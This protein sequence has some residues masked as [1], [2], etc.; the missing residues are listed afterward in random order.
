MKVELV[1]KHEGTHS[2][3]TNGKHLYFAAEIQAWL[4]IAR[5]FSAVTAQSGIQKPD[6]KAVKRH[7]TYT[8][9]HYQKTQNWAYSRLENK[10][11]TKHVKKYFWSFKKL[12]FL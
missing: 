4:W 8:Y 6:S 3:Q 5:E 2:F 11:T 9:M 10:W 1:Q 12:L 7:E